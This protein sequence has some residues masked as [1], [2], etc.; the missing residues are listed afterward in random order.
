MNEMKTMDYILSIIVLAYGL[1]LTIQNIKVFV[2]NQKARKEY[3]AQ[4]KDQYQMINQYYP[5]AALFTVLSI[6]SLVVAIIGDKTSKNDVYTC[7]A[8]VVISMI[9]FGMVL[10]AIV[11][12]RAIIDKNGFVYEDAY[13]RFRSI[14]SMEPKKSIF[15]NIDILTAQ[16][17]H[18]IVTKKMGDILQAGYQ[19]WKHRKSKDNK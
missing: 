4:S 17:E 8:L 16:K 18:I 3:L 2:A 10:V 12:R 5:F 19:E 7:M 15:K 14:L 6:A 9:A 13:H 11:K 1:Y